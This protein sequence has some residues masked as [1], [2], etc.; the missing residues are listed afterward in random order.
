MRAGRAKEYLRND[1]YRLADVAAMLGY[2]DQACFTR[3]FQRWFG[4]SPRAWRRDL[5]GKRDPE[6]DR[7][8]VT[9]QPR[10]DR[11]GPPLRHAPQESGG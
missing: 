10:L 1:Y 9:N 4:V 8:G 5:H 2:A 11:G 3:S 7:A 6:Q